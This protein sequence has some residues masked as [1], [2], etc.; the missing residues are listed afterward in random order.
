MATDRIELGFHA[1]DSADAIAQAKA[2]VKGEPSLRLR[3][4]ASARPVTRDDVATG[5]WTVVVVVR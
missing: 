2:W 3:T 5:R 1:T 4:I